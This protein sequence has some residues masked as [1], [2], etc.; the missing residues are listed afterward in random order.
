M[1]G[2][3]T[4]REKWVKFRYSRSYMYDSIMMI[5]SF[6]TMCEVK[7]FRNGNIVM[8]LVYN[9][10]LTRGGLKGGSLGKCQGPR[11]FGGPRAQIFWA[12]WLFMA[13]CFSGPHCTILGGHIIYVAGRWGTAF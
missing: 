5:S 10:T 3:V 2:Q 1:T 6:I 7:L 4:G 9:G 12:S 8:S 11:A 13:P